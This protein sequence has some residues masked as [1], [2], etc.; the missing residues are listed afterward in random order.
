MDYCKRH[1]A[2]IILCM[3]T[4]VLAANDGAFYAKGNQLIP[5]AE[6]QITVKKEILELRKI[7][8]KYIQVS[9][10]YEFDNPGN[11]KE[12]VVGFEAFSPSGD[13]DGT[14]VKGAHPFI[15]DFS[16]FVN[17]QNIPHKIAYVD[18][19][20][21]TKNGLVQSKNLKSLMENMTN[22]N[23]VNFYYVYHFNATF[24][25]GKNIIRHTYTYDLSGSVEF[26][27]NF[28]YVLSAAARWGN[29]Q[30]DDFTLIYEPENF[31]SFYIN[32]NFFDDGKEWLVNGSGVC[33]DKESVYGLNVAGFIIK[34][35]KIEWHKKNFA[36]KAELFVFTPN[37]YPYSVETKLPFSYYMDEQIEKPNTQK[38]IKILKNL[39]YARRGYVFKSGE[40]QSYFEKQEWYIKDSMYKADYAMLSEQ[41]KKWLKELDKK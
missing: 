30:I 9:V 24:R 4:L 19:S 34:N 36:P 8:N 23:E 38:E 39:P 32:R 21:Y 11:E 25:K 28:E 2:T 12:C 14:P 29:H 40:L 20:L 3:T 18:D 22:V 15:H 26:A 10:Y 41:E 33:K 6:T 13:V 5:V 31:E 7:R 35:G 37:E 17:D 16:V 1:I 27:Y